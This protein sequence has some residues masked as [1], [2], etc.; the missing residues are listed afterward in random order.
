MNAADILDA[1][2]KAWP[3]VALWLSPSWKSETNTLM[4]T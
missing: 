3:S 1:L 4:P 2:R